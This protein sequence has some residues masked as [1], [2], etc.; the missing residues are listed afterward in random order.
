MQA[1]TAAVANSELTASSASSLTR[2]SIEELAEIEIS[3]VSKRP[4][5]L[6]DASASVFVITREDIRHFG[7]AT[8]PEA[9]RL[10]PNLQVARTNANSYAITARGFNSSS[11]NKLLVM[12][13]GRSIYTPLHAGVFW[14]A[15]DVVL[16]DVERIEVI[17]GPG[18]ALWGANAFSGVINILTRSAKDTTGTHVTAAAGTS[19]H[20]LTVRHGLRLGEAAVRGYVKQVNADNSERA[21][22]SELADDWKRTQAGFRADWGDAASAWTLQGDAYDGMAKGEGQPDRDISGA[23]LLARWS[24]QFADGSAL[25]VQGYVD[26]YSRSQP[27]FFSEDL[28]TVDIDVQHQFSSAR[29]HE[30]VWGGGYREHDDST[31]GGAL[32]AFVPAQKKL[33][34]ANVFAQ[35]TVSLGERLKLTFGLKL[36]HN[37]YTGWESQPNVRLAWKAGEQSL[38]WSGVSHAVRTPSRLDRDFFVFVPLAPPY[39]GTLLGGPDFVSEKVTAYEIGYR[40]Q[41]T[42]S[43]SFSISGYYNDYDRLRSIEPAEPGTF[44]LGNEVEGRAYGIE[45]WARMQINERWRVGA[46]LNLLRQRLAFTPASADPG[47]PS[48]GGND[49]KYQFQLRS[50]HSLPNDLELD[51]GLRAVGALPQPPVPSYVALDARLAWTVRRGL[52]ASLAGWNLLDEQHPEWGATPGRSEVGRSLSLRLTWNL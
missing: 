30:I 45:S 19:E 44:V 17:S 13:D 22:G 41:P 9:L 48:S 32:L 5:R 50:S 34:L 21:D 8:L 6:A 15:Q 1:A 16:A 24:R 3:S 47:S 35:D 12:I 42:P 27:G 33:K 26:R 10:A 28:D 52:E 7:A 37:S 40:D 49:P 31:S 39:N 18:G 25:Q 29:A 36:E 2:L 23:N 4:E 51:L 46:G 14:D 11:A 20:V 38:L 43:T